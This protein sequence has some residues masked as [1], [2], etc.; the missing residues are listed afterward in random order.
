MARWNETE[1]MSWGR[2]RRVPMRLGRPERTADLSALLA[3]AGTAGTIAIGAGL[4]YGDAPLNT[5]GDGILFS[6]L[7]RLLSF[8]AASGDLAAEAGVTFRDMIQTFLPRGYLPP[9]IPGTSGVTLGGAVA[10][11]IH[12]KNHDHAGSFGHHVQWL[13]LI[14]ADGVSRRISPT[15]EP[16]LFAAT[17]GGIGLT[18]IIHRV[19]V[20]L[21]PVPSSFVTVREIR[22]RNLGELMAALASHREKATYSVA[23]LDAL[24]GG[25]SLGRGVLE[26][27]E[28]AEPNATQPAIKMSA[29]KPVFQVPFN[30]PKIALN[31]MGGSVFNGI[32]YRRTADR[33]RTRERPIPEFLFPLDKL[34]AWNRLYGRPGF[35]QFQC[36]IPEAEAAAGISAIFAALKEHYLPVYLAVLKTLGENGLGLLSF[37]MKGYTLTL[38]IPNRGQARPGLAA[39]EAV[40]RN[41]GGRVYLAKDAALSTAGFREMYPA[42]ETLRSVIADTGAIGTFQS[43]MARRFGLV[44]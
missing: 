42:F 18:G 9:V 26:L 16:G 39:L 31:R 8:D 23:W 43:D 10:N 27:A 37:P 38:D 24:A 25:A 21:M 20:R 6:R 28:L 3:E 22:C 34:S 30:A 7:N 4:S 17:V 14:T 33:G 15:E 32:Y 40:V 44:E 29:V 2:T 5:G 1:F 41:H 19:C 12:G 35:F 13:D 11:D 36:V